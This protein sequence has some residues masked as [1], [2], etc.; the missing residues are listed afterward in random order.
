MSTL[1]AYSATHC[2]M[3]YVPLPCSSHVFTVDFN[4]SFWS[5]LPP[6]YCSPFKSMV[7]ALFLLSLESIRKGNDCLTYFLEVKR[8]ASV[9]LARFHEVAQ[10]A[11]WCF[12]LLKMSRGW[13]AGFQPHP[14]GFCL[15]VLVLWWLLSGSTS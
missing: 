6:F 11:A 12:G 15:K 4:L 8:L 3:I 2:P 9:V 7:F 5:I 10:D 13:I 14:W 1:V